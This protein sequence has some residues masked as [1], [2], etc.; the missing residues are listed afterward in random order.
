MLVISA[1]AL[2]P[3]LVAGVSAVKANSSEIASP[4]KFLPATTTLAAATSPA[5]VAAAV[6][7]IF[8]G[9]AGCA[10]NS[11]TT[12]ASAPTPLGPS[13]PSTI[14]SVSAATANAAGMFTCARKE[15]STLTP[16]ASV[17]IIWP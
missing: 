8:L 5:V 2:F 14:P 3:V 11:S 1:K 16:S 15:R 12:R 4:A 17:L 13:A 6:T 10:R 9:H 7:V